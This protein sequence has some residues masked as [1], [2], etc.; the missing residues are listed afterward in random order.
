MLEYPKISN[1]FKADKT[2]FIDLLEA[3]VK[4]EIHRY[5]S[6]KSLDLRDVKTGMK[7][8]GMEETCRAY[9]TDEG[10]FK[11]IHFAFHSKRYNKILSITVDNNLNFIRTAFGYNPSGGHIEDHQQYRFGAILDEDMIKILMSSKTGQQ[12]FVEETLPELHQIGVYDFNSDNF[13]QRLDLAN[14]VL[15]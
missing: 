13:K 5:A 2:G 1:F 15:I 3:I 14:M 10:R 12:E 7:F 11:N 8:D 9:F 4:K 6:N